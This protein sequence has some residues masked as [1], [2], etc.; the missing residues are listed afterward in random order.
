MN[1][2]VRRRRGL[3][4]FVRLRTRSQRTGWRGLWY[5]PLQLIGP[6]TR[7]SPIRRGLQVL[8]LLAFL[9]AFFYVCWPYAETF[10]EDTFSNKE[11]FQVELFLLIDPLVGLST[12][13][14]GR[15][16]NGATLWWAAAILAVCLLVPR[17]FC[18]YLCPLGT[19][20]DA[21]DWL[22][23]RRLRWPHVRDGG[24]A[25]WWVHLRY[26][27]LAAVL[28]SSLFGVLLSGFVAAIPVLT[29]GLMFTAARLQL[30]IMKG[31]SQLAPVGW[32]FYLSIGLFLAVFLLS[33]FGRRFWCRYV[34]PSGALFSVGNLL[35]IGQRK[36]ENT[37]IDCH[38][39]V[40]ICPF[41]AIREDHTTR[42]ANCTFCQTCGGVCPPGA[43]QFVTRFQRDGFRPEDGPAVSPR[44]LSRRAFVATAAAAAGTAALVQFRSPAPGGNPVRPLRPPGS[45][46][47]DLFLDLC[48]RCA[49]CFKVCPGPVLHPA[50]LE[51]GWESLWTPVAN[52]DHAGC[53]QDCNFCTLVCPTGAIQ[54]LEIAAKR[55]FHMGLA[56]VDTETCL[57]FRQ[58]DRRE[59]D[60]CYVECRQAGYDAIEMREIEIQ[61]DPPPPEGM[62][63]ELEL[64]EMSRIRAPFVKAAA[65]V[66]CGICQYRCHA[67]YVAQRQILD[68]SAIRVFAG[69]EHRL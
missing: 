38:R 60:A 48:I 59:C 29:R 67:L 43:I 18:G 2:D 4:I 23:G 65:C 19:L 25:G 21:F 62:F 57:P 27:L 41:D 30:A 58:T 53:H 5:A 33:L 28:I 39:C 31:P 63:S 17:G 24:T 14:A 20:I 46:P 52:L 22:V 10:N 49:Q 35:R 1:R 12:A 47:E 9:Y 42:T 56:R 11:S 7:A 54:P 34:C 68:Q 26:Y 3:N 15:F 51:Y 40:E 13:L 69:H 6:V 16:V 32:T 64:L 44:P 61:L 50:G 8:C 55:R 45:V 36:V 37:C 66:G